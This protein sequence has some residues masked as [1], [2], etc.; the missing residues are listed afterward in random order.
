MHCID[1]CPPF[2]RFYNGIICVQIP[3]FHLQFFKVVYNLVNPLFHF[4]VRVSRKTIGS[5]L[6]PFGQIGIPIMVGPRNNL[7]PVFLFVC[8]IFRKNAVNSKN[9][10][11]GTI[12]F[13]RMIQTFDPLV[14]RPDN[15]FPHTS[16]KKYPR[17]RPPKAL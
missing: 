6:N 14:V 10:F 3:V 4:L 17:R 5:R 13:L 15:G 7:F 9:T 2:P 1:V 8:K 12:V 11:P 16:S